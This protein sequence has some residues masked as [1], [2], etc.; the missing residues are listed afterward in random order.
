LAFAQTK[1][2][3]E[4]YTYQASEYD[5]KVSC[6]VLALEQV[7]R[8]LLEKLGTYLESETEVKNFQ[9]TKDQIVILTAGIVSA[10]IIDERWDGKTYYLKAKIAADPREVIK[11][12]DLMRQDRQKTR[13][14]EEI[15]KKAN[16]ALREVEKLRKE[17]EIA[18]GGKTEQD[19][20]NK[21][22]N[23]LSAT[24]WSEKGYALVN[25]GNWQ[26][27]GGAFTRAIE[28]DPENADAYQGRGIAYGLLG[29]YQQ[30]IMDHDKAIELDPKDA[31]FYLVR[32]LLYSKVGNYQQAIM[33]YDKAIELEIKNKD[34]QAIAYL[35]RGTSYFRLK[36]YRQAI[37]DFDRAIQL[38]PKDMKAYL[39]RGGAYGKL[40]NHQQAIKNYDRAIQLDPKSATTY[41]VRGTSYFSLKDYP[42]A[43]RDH[44][45]AAKLGN[46]EAQ[47]YLRSKGISW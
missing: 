33:D 12:I 14:L 18:R 45:T 27:A 31:Y 7:K 17:L 26:N 10:E 47:E 29:N 6:R 25:D 44:K 5:S 2:F 34:L 13:D 3:V 23:R 8:L 43:I 35:N 42:R 4:E 30:A 15:R 21:A 1:V 11:S 39:F 16:E 38:D 46:K 28:L 41:Y 19:Q 20:Y 37:K 24:N 36:D 9:L 32:G 22:V 40:G